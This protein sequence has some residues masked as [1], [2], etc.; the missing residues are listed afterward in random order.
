[1]A[2]NLNGGAALLF[3]LIGMNSMVVHLLLAILCRFVHILQYL[4][5]RHICTYHANTP[6]GLP[7][8]STKWGNI[9]LRSNIAGRRNV[10]CLSIPHMQYRK[11]SFGV[12]PRFPLFRPKHVNAIIGFLMPGPK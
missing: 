2:P 5:S 3:L 12:L 7:M 8:T 9:P 4:R 1:M 6:M 10:R 11:A